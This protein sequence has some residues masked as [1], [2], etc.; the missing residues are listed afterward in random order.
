MKY[1]YLMAAMLGFMIQ[2]HMFLTTRLIVGTVNGW[3]KCS[4]VTISVF[5]Y[6]HTWY[7]PKHPYPEH[8]KPQKP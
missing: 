2:S 8:C 5:G 1:R 3:N 7:N 6:S 4:N